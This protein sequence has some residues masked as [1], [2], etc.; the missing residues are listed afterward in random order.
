LS[1]YDDDQIDIGIDDFNALDVDISAHNTPDD[2]VAE[3]VAKAE[4]EEV[5]ATVVNAIVTDTDDIDYLFAE[6]M[7]M[8]YAH[9]VPHPLVNGWNIETE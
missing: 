1:K 8:R 7:M 9:Y 3:V 2:S 4:M 6:E 5:V